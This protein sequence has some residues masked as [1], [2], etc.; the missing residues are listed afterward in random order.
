MKL[1]AHVIALERSTRL[2]AVSWPG[3]K[4]RGCQLKGCIFLQSNISILVPNITHGLQESTEPGGE[5]ITSLLLF[6]NPEHRTR[7]IKNQQSQGEIA[8]YSIYYP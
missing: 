6:L 3:P 1:S 4:G 8:A 5:G 2:L 7:E